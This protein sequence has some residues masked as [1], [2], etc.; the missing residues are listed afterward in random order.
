[1]GDVRENVFAKAHES[2]IEAVLT[3]AFIKW[4]VGKIRQSPA[5]EC[6][7]VTQMAVDGITPATATCTGR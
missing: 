5:A 2:G 6:G 7:A 4:N 1:M 3:H